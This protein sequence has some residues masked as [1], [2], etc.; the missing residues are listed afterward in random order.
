M[1]ND[2]LKQKLCEIKMYKVESS[3]INYLGYDENLQI[4]KVIFRNDSSYAYFGV[5]S[6]IWNQLCRSES[7]GKFLTE[8]IT[9]RSDLYKFVKII[10]I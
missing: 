1:D 9:R 6:V 4:L 2:Q 5:P 10:R 3:N 7:K 8:N